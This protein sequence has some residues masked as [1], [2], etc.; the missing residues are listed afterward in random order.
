MAQRHDENLLTSHLKSLTNIFKKK[1]A[2][3]VSK[4]HDFGIVLKDHILS[5]CIV[6]G[7]FLCCF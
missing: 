2:Q 1:K 4:E 3:G 5:K 7:F 6:Q